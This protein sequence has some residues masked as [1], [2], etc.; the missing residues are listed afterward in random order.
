M[1][2]EVPPERTRVK[3][4]TSGKHVRMEDI[5][6]E[7]GK[8]S[9]ITCAARDNTT[10][11]KSGTYEIANSSILEFWNSMK[12][13]GQYK[14]WTIPVKIDKMCGLMATMS[15]VERKKLSRLGA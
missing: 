9:C 14:N 5:G 1:H 12:N 2:C 3:Q 7:C 6:K 15:K 11:F 8:K 13:N 10:G 4:K